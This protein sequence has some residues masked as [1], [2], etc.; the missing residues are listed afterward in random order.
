[1][2]RVRHQGMTAKVIGKDR[3]AGGHSFLFR[4]RLKAPG[5]PGGR[6]TFDDERGGVVIELVDMRPDPAMLGFL[7]DKRKGIIEFLM[8]AQPDELAFAQI[9]IGLEHTCVFA[10]D[11]RVDP[12]CR[13]HQI[14]VAAIILG[15]FEFSF[16]LQ[17][18]AQFAR[19]GLQDDQ[20]R[21]AANSGKAMSA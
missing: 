19:P 21:L 7:E 1:M 11:G 2:R 18:H 5:V 3:L 8:R 17:I 15:S 10:A 12:I 4:H 6:Q 9:D 20:H 16:K 14:V 13:H